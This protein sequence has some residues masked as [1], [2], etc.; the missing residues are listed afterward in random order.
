MR[1][2]MATTTI[3]ALI[4]SVLFPGQLLLA[5]SK[6]FTMI[7][8]EKLSRYDEDRILYQHFEKPYNEFAPDAQDN[9]IAALMVIKDKNV[10][11]FKDGY[12]DPEAV[13][14][15]KILHDRGNQFLPDLWPNKIEGVPNFVM[16]TDRKIE[17]QRNATKE[18]VAN[19]YKD[20]YLDVRNRF[21][22]K[23]AAIFLSLIV[24]RKDIEIAVDRTRIPRKMSDGDTVKYSTW[25][26]ART[27]DG[28]TVYY[29]ED[30]DGD[31]ISETFMVHSS[32]GF[33]WGFKT[34]TN[35]INIQN[36]T[37]KDIESI[38]GWL[39]NTAYAGSPIEDELIKKT[40]PSS[41]TVGDMIDDIY[42]IDS[43]TKTFMKKKNIDLEAEVD[44]KTQAK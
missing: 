21:L 2:P 32:D 38:I 27:G 44:K 8:V 30:A 16:I 43:E 28:G 34:G 40:F 15:N 5:R 1:R 22:K 11:L 19:N 18:F 12:D 37:Q 7:N 33:G 29:A 42:Y 35:L 13:R 10:Y 23:H 39:T 20:F 14:N 3:L 4:I 26:S 36:N 9:S 31:G 41:G 17:L 6:N 24:N 25:V